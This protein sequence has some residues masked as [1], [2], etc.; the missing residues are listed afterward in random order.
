MV[1]QPL[2]FLVDRLTGVKIISGSLGSDRNRNV[3]L[4]I[5]IQALKHSNH[6]HVLLYEYRNLRVVFG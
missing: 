3:A 5:Y 2:D 1:A 4:S 6:I